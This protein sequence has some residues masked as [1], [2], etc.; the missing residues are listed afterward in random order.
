MATRG[1]ERNEK[2]RRK[3]FS[4]EERRN[5]LLRIAVELFSERGFEGT[6]T[7]AIAAAAGVSE[8][9]I[10]QHF[11]SKEDLYSGILDY[12][13]KAA[14]HQEWKDQLR[15]LAELE[16]DESL[17]LSL[18]ERILEAN[19]SDP[20]FQRLAFQ[21]A[22]SGHPLPKLMAQ[23]TLPLHQFLCSYITKRQKQGAFRKCDPNVALHAMISLP[24]YYGLAKSIF[25]FNM[26]KL[27]DHELAL[28][29]TRLILEGLR[30]PDGLPR[31][32]EKK[33]ATAARQTR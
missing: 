12:K 23:R 30:T 1:T 22:L 19:R 13:A 28:S 25:G 2:R 7:K 11:A 9:V 27:S 18:V 20:Q 32:K 14:G 15:H 16:N 6:T 5:Q 26:I 24:S 4:A 8:A 31:R 21:A 33:D 29:F 3:R 10:F 17:V